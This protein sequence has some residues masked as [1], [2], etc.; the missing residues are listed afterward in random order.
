MVEDAPT[1]LGVNRANCRS[2]VP[3]SKSRQVLMRLQVTE[4][5]QKSLRA[6][7]LHGTVCLWQAQPGVDNAVSHS[8]SEALG[9]PLRSA[10]GGCVNLK[11]LS[12]FDVC[13]RRLQALHIAA[14]SYLRLAVSTNDGVGL[15]CWQPLLTLLI[16]TLQ[17]NRGHEHTGMDA[18]WAVLHSQLT[19]QSFCIAVQ[20]LETATCP[21]IQE[22]TSTFTGAH[23]SFI[24]AVLPEVLSVE[25]RVLSQALHGPFPCCDNLG[26]SKP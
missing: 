22:C 20:I 3:T 23:I 24:F 1:L 7:V 19:K 21:H 10:N 25:D 4:L 11:F 18:D 15:S 5:H 16:T 8:A 12:L 14:M 2:D 6:F 17:S 13:G 26:A 9:P